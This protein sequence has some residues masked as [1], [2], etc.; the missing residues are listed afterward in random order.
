MALATALERWLE[1]AKIHQ[2]IGNIR[3]S[4]RKN[5]RINGCVVVFTQLFC[6]DCHLKIQVFSEVLQPLFA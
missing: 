5:I 3:K 2:P 1:L 6:D 4:P